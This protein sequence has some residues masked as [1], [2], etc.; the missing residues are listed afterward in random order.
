MVKD[1]VA[2]LITHLKNANDSGKESILFPYSKLGVA[3]AEALERSGFVKGISKKGKK[4]GRFIEIK[5]VYS[6]TKPKILGVERVSKFSKRV[7]VGVKDIRPVRD[8]FG[9]LVLSTT[10]GILTDREAR[11]EKTGGEAL[12]KIW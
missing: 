9:V 2:D 10:K 8:G 4:V 7:Y 3:V 5:L 11:K 1:Y 6:D 12:F